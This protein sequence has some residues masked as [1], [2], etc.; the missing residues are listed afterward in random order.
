VRE[1][2]IV[3]E[4]IESRVQNFLSAKE[5]WDKALLKMAYESLREMMLDAGVLHH[6]TVW[7]GKPL[8]IRLRPKYCGVQPGKTNE[9]HWN[10][11]V[12][13]ASPQAEGEEG[14]REISWP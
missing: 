10:V 6:E 5:G 14:S 8:T 7:D 2:G 11:E 3:R 1:E 4:L 12:E 13:Y 9:V